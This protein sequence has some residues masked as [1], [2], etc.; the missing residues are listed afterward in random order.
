VYSPHCSGEAFLDSLESIVY[1]VDEKMS[2]G[3]VKQEV[4]QEKKFQARKQAN[5]DSPDRPQGAPNAV[6]YDIARQ[7]H[8][9]A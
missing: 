8:Q 4:L 2:S 5:N 6:C 7:V 3:A 1:T 9:K